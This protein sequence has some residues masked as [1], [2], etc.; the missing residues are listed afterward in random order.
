MTSM[1]GPRLPIAFLTDEV[2]HEQIPVVFRLEMSNGKVAE[3]I[4]ELTGT[5]TAV[6][7]S[8]HTLTR[9]EME[10]G[11]DLPV[12]DETKPGA[13]GQGSQRMKG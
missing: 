2:E 10:R 8:C 5:R 13:A 11:G 7:H 9:E 6:L 1:S 3:A 4:A 12:F